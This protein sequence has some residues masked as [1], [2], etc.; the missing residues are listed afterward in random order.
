MIHDPLFRALAGFGIALITGLL[1]AWICTEHAT[2]EKPGRLFR[3]YIS[4]MRQSKNG[5]Y[6]RHRKTFSL[7]EQF[8]VIAF[9]VSFLLFMGSIL[10]FSLL[11]M[12][13]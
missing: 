3:A 5:D 12:G 13:T 1:V 11:G 2:P 9:T 10:A 4:F 6:L 7:R 8:L